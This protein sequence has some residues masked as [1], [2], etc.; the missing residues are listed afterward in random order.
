[1]GRRSKPSAAIC[2]SSMKPTMFTP[3]ASIPEDEMNG[4]LS[5]EQMEK[6]QELERGSIV[7]NNWILIRKAYAQRVK[8]RK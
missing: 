1:M 4:I 3:L 2:V 8:G 7:V 6:W 5:R